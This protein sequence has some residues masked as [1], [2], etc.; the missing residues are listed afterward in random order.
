MIAAGSV[1]S[2]G[3]D[4]GL[5]LSRVQY[6]RLADVLDSL[7]DDEWA[8]PTDCA[9][10]DVKAVA[11]HVLGNL[12]GTRS[13]RELVRQLRAARRLG[14]DDWLDALNDVQVRAHAAD[15]PRQVA[16]RLRELVEP[17]LRMRARVPLPLRRL[18]RLSLPVSGRVPLAWVLDVI[19]TRDTFLHR[20]DVCRATGR[21]VVVDESERRVVADIVAE[22]A[23][24]HGEPFVLRLT[25]PAGATYTGGPGGEEIECDAVEFARLVSG[26]GTPR[27]LLTASVQ[28]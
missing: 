21:D 27:G 18:V 10:W 4:E 28:F 2:I 23:A 17:A 19:Y 7:R 6:V 11:A 12:E 26:R 15:P 9:G 20:V 14:Y 5:R 8:A 3:R 16:A 24:R 25:G 1:E 22:W 13:P